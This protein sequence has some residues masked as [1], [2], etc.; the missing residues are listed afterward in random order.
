ME[1]IT[2]FEEQNIGFGSYSLFFRVA[3]W[4]RMRKISLPRRDTSEKAAQATEDYRFQ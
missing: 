4:L 1:I 3:V 2:L